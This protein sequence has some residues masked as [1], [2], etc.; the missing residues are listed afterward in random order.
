MLPQTER[1]PS[2]IGLQAPPVNRSSDGDFRVEEEEGVHSAFLVHV[3][4]RYCASG[5]SERAPRDL[6]AHARRPLAQCL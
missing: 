4:V 2:D 5:K 6:W 1:A 3:S